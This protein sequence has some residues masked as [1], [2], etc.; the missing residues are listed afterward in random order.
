MVQ[1]TPEHYRWESFIF[2]LQ[3][4]ISGT[5]ATVSNNATARALEGRGCRLLQYIDA[6]GKPKM[7]KIV[8]R[9]LLLTARA[10]EIIPWSIMPLYLTMQITIWRDIIDVIIIIT[11]ITVTS[12][13]LRS[14]NDYLDLL[15][16]R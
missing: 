9:T 14:S 16:Y 4:I 1:I 3:F 5:Q 10:L 7:K 6:I 2:S 8:D 13:D 15:M 12:N 11:S